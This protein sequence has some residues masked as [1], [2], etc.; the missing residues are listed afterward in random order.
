MNSTTDGEQPPISETD[1]DELPSD[2]APKVENPIDT[3][4]Y[5]QDPCLSL[6]SA[7]VQQ[8]DLPGDGK[9]IGMPLGKACDWAD[10]RTGGSIQIGFL[11]KDPRGLSSEY[12][13]DNDGKL[14]LFLELPPIEGF[15]AVVRGIVD[16][17]EYGGCTVVVGASDEIAFEVITQLPHDNVDKEEPCEVSTYVAGVALQNV[18]EG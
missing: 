9:P 16:D 12:K 2:G 18:K 10:R 8:L 14:K 11:D 5:Q 6:T 1:S 13:A 4:K 17:R 7:Q 15:P 3:V